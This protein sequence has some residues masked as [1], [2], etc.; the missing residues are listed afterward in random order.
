M[1]PV[2]TGEARSA[3]AEQEQT[4]LWMH[5]SGARTNCE[6]TEVE[7]VSDPSDHKGGEGYRSTYI[8]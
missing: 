5:A 1:W 3:G 4:K 7:H 6:G 2:A 8:T